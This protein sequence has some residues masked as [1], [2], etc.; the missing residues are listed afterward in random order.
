[1][2]KE[3]NANLI[4]K[5]HQDLVFNY[6]EYPTK[7][8]WSFG[9]KNDEYKNALIDWFPRNQDKKIFFYIHIPFCEQLCWFCTCSK[10][11]TKD[12]EKVKDY[13]NYLYK[14]IDILFTFLNKNKIQLNVGT[15]FFGG[16]SPTILNKEDLK[17]LVEKL[18]G[19]FDWSK[20]EFFTIESDPRRVDEDR[21]IYNHEVCGANRISFGMQDFDIEVQKRV[22]RIQPSKLFEDILTDKV[23]KVYKE[24]A[25]DLLIGQPG[26][27]PE[28]MSKTCDE[29]LKLKP[30]L[31][32]LSLMAYKPWVAKYQIQMVAEGPLPDFLER[33]ELL[34]VIHEKLKSG[35]YIRTGF[36]CYSLP[37]SPMTKAFKEGEAH[38]GAAG[39]QPGGRV[40]FVA[41]GSSS[42]SN[43]GNDYY[44]QNFYD[45]PSYRKALDNNML[46]SFRGIKL[47]EDDKI[48][49]HATQQI[50]SYFKLDFKNFN[51]QFNI[52]FAKYFSKEIKYLDDMIKDGLVKVSEN[53]IL[54]TEIGRDF[55]Q[56]IMNIFDKYDP[57]EKSYKE[58]LETIKKAKTAQSEILERI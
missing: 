38:Y 9:F 34:E 39:H 52:D 19:L 57:P 55:T 15:V 11:I 49:Q 26:Q 23:R 33:K 53:E 47:N 10:F 13:L 21:L 32:Q 12:Y 36:E 3:L 46:P 22:N 42:M 54:L 6:A 16:G 27:T 43:L 30:T 58:R 29:I 31:V 48:R 7:D 41:V 20:V 1:M 28:G 24:I 56:V 5:Y 2:N 35:G 44:V 17:K 45:L 25:F 51:E 4:K 18:K 50:R 40:N 14:E 8:H 37:D